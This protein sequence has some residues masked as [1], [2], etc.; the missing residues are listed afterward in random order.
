MVTLKENTFRVLSR[1]TSCWG[2]KKP[3]KEVMLPDPGVYWSGQQKLGG[4]LSNK[5]TIHY[6]ELE[7]VS[8]IGPV[9]W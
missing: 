3:D 2:S 8:R 9:D 7:S 1:L 5:F 6:S 4:Q